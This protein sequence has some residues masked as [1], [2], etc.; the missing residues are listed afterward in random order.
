MAMELEHLAAG[1]TLTHGDMRSD[2]CRK[3]VED[4]GFGGECPDASETQLAMCAAE[5][6]EA[7]TSWFVPF[8]GSHCPTNRRFKAR[9]E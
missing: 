1:D 7:S 8:M 2:I 9:S 6:R 5:A 3:G 4:G